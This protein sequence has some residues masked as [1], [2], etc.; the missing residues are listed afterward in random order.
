LLS[1]LSLRRAVLCMEMGNDFA[2][3]P[4]HIALVAAQ[5]ISIEAD[6][7]ARRHMTQSVI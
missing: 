7:N 6:Y 3:R 5:R 1:I 4:S 2:T